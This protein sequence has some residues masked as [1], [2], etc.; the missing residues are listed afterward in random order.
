[1]T[2]GCVALTH[3]LGRSYNLTDMAGGTSSSNVAGAPVYGVVSGNTLTFF[4]VAVDDNTPFFTDYNGEPFIV[5][6]GDSSVAV[7]TGAVLASTDINDFSYTIDTSSGTVL[8]N[9]GLITMKFLWNSNH[10]WTRFW[11]VENQILTKN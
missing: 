7:G 8:T 10:A 6:G 1:M 2:K 9:S 11:T 3:F 5:C 4:N